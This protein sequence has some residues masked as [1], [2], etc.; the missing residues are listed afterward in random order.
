MMLRFYKDVKIQTFCYI[1]NTIIKVLISKA[2][3]LFK[4]RFF[5]SKELLKLKI[6]LPVH[7]HEICLFFLAQ[8]VG[9]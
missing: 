8:V 2:I 6:V 3:R 4:N 5:K 1:G 7:W 9:S